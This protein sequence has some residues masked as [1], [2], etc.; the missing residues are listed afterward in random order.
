MNTTTLVK[1]LRLTNL[2]IAS[3]LAL[4]SA[5][6]W[7]EEARNK[8]EAI[9]IAKSQHHGKVLKVES[10]NDVYVVR[11]LSQDGRITQLKIPRQQPN[12]SAKRDQR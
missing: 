12:S 3:I 5:S 9:A 8:H 1:T 2:L 7:A 4:S 10:R 6:G 11:M